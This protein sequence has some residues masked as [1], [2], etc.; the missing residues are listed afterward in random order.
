MKPAAPCPARPAPGEARP[1]SGRHGRGRL[2]FV[3]LSSEETAGD[4]LR[5]LIPADI[6]VFCTRTHLADPVTVRNLTA[7]GQD[8]ARAAALL[9]PALDAIAY[10]CTSGSAVLGEE[11]VVRALQAGQPGTRAISLFACAV[12]A[13]RA[14]A[15]RRPALATPYLDEV[16]RAEAAALAAAGFRVPAVRGLGI[17]SGRDMCL[18]EPA[19]IV[20]MALAADRPEADGIFVSCSAL[21]SVEAIEEIERRAGKPAVTSNQAL[22]WRMLRLT[23]IEDR[24]EGCGRLLREL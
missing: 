24:I 6:G 23:G 16:N 17:E 9:P 11:A 19:A 18:V 5:A 3:L 21:R 14:L 22:V 2:G 10:V 20:E 4:D 13:M 8:L 15:I 7:V 12:A 1:G